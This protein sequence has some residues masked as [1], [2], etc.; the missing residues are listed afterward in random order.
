MR[1]FNCHCKR[2]FNRFASFSLKLIIWAANERS[3]LASSYE[4][5]T[6]Y[7][8]LARWA[9]YWSL[10]VIIFFISSRELIRSIEI[11]TSIKRIW[12]NCFDW[13]N[14]KKLSD[15]KI[16]SSLN[17]IEIVEINFFRFLNVKRTRANSFSFNVTN[18]SSA[19]I[20]VSLIWMFIISKWLM[21]F[22]RLMNWINLI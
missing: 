6:M 22:N 9:M 19:K 2:W 18:S 16:R 3:K 5:M 4:T 13:V 8:L 20:N 1:L 10:E 11:L 17:L 7:A 15:K 14:N 12:L 21:K